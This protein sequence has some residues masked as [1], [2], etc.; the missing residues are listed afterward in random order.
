M[1][2]TDTRHLSR[3]PI[4]YLV[5]ADFRRRLIA[6]A[7]VNRDFALLD[8]S[9]VDLCRA[10]RF[11]VNDVESNI[12]RTPNDLFDQMTND[13]FEEGAAQVTGCAL[14]GHQAIEDVFQPL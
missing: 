4:L 11:R 12:D 7:F 10:A 8:Q 1:I 14:D 13:Q 6:F 2:A 5:T 9:N 3:N